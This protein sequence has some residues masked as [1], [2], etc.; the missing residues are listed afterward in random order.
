VGSDNFRLRG[1]VPVWVATAEAGLQVQTT[2]RIGGR[3]G[4]WVIAL[5]LFQTG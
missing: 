1:D 3:S 2:N 4:F 5:S